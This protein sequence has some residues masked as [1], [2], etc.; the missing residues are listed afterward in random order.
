M[1]YGGARHGWVMV[2]ASSNRSVWCLFTK[3]LD[4]FLSSSNTLW[5]QGRTSN[6]AVGGGQNGKKSFKIN[7]QR[8]LW[9]FEISR[10]ISEHNMLKGDTGVIVYSINGRTM[11]EFTFEFTSANLALRVSKSVTGKKVVT[12][13]NPNTPHKSN[14]SGLVMLKIAPGIQKPI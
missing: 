2:P 12:W 11:H 8:K 9:N 3:E 6:E 1:Y 5:V 7:N 4:R 14:N 13:M 10:A